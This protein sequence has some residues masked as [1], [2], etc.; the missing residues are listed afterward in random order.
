M[1]KKLV[2]YLLISG[3]MSAAGCDSMLADHPVD[4]ARS[5]YELSYLA[6]LTHPTTT[7]SGRVILCGLNNNGNPNVRVT[8]GCPFENRTVYTDSN[9]AFSF[10]NV[11]TG[12]YIM[13][14]SKQGHRLIP[15]RQEITVGLADVADVIFETSVTWEK[16]IG[17][18]SWEKAYSVQQTDDCGYVVA[19]YTDSHDVGNIDAYI[20]KL[21]INGNTEWEKTIGGDDTDIAYDIQKTSDGGYVTAG[22]TYSSGSGLGDYYIIK[23]NSNG[24]EEWQKIYGGSERDEARSIS[25]TADNGFIITGLSESYTEDVCDI[26]VL[27]TDE[28]GDFKWSQT[29][30]YFDLTDKSFSIQRTSDG[31]SVIAGTTEV[32]SGDFDLLVFKINPTGTIVWSYLSDKGAYDES[33]SVQE[34]KDEG[35]IVCGSSGLDSGDFWC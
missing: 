22:I 31:G 25:Q 5:L 24:E 23:L 17:G 29:Y 33:Y 2:I 12:K 11:R 21:D 28:N 6:H 3:L 27:S 34:T 30:N 16:T 19:G 35:F 32:T 8:L 10:N 13:S 14:A 1:N 20:V 26:W 4:K 18:E 7:V 9:G 15:D